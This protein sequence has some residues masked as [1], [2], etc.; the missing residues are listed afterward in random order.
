MPGGRQ[1][2]AERGAQGQ[3]SAAAGGLLTSGKQ[4]QI[5]GAEEGKLAFA[6]A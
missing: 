6:P 2:R 3:R 5:E 1:S 4:G